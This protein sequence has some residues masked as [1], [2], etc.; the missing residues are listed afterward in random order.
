[1]TNLNH[2]IATHHESLVVIIVFLGTLLTDDFDDL[3]DV[4]SRN[5]LLKTILE[6]LIAFIT[7]LLITLLVLELMN[8]R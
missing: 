3:K 1:M 4:E 2:L 7:I 5:E 6:R 8:L